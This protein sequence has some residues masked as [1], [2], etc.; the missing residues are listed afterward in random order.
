ME[1]FNITLPTCWDDLSDKQLLMVY[2]LFSRDLATA[3]VKTLCLMKWNQLKVLATLPAHRFLIKRKKEQVVLSTRQIQQANSV[4]D[5]LD[6]FAPMPVRISR[7]GKYRALPADFE[8]V[9]FEQYLF[10]DNLF[11]GYLN[12]QSDELLL[13][14][15]QVLY[16]SDDVKPS[17]AHLVGIFY[18]MASLKQYF[19]SLFPNFYKP[20]SAMGETNLLGSGQQDIYSQLREST[21]AMIRALTGGDI[22]KESAI[23]KMDTWRALT[24]L[25]AKAKEVE[26]LRKAYKKP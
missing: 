17:K 26:E 23:M 25:D 8:K 5:Y 10:V 24:E 6:S 15:A 4:L 21:N 20:A 18:W 3:E 13:Q 12:T 14:I 7:I 9:P 22:T 16:A 19:A 2:S 1:T 11:Q